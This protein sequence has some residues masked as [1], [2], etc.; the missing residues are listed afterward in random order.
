MQRW[1]SV[2]VFITISDIIFADL[3]VKPKVLY[4]LRS[5]FTSIKAEENE[6]QFNGYGQAT[7]LAC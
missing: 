3:Y 5:W 1:V 4:I 6:E 7:A 2:Q